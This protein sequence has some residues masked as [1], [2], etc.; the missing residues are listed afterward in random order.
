MMRQIMQDLHRIFISTG[1]RKGIF[2]QHVIIQWH[3]IDTQIN[4]LFLI[5]QLVHLILDIG[6]DIPACILKQNDGA[7]GIDPHQTFAVF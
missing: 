1:Q 3:T 2:H 4:I 7:A 6:I 5:D